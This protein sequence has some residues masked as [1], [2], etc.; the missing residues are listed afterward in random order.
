[1]TSLHYKDVI[2]SAMASQSP[3]LRLFNQLF[4]QAQIRFRHR[5]KKTS[6]L[7]VTGFCE[8]N[9]PVTG[10]F[11]AQRASNAE[12]VS[13]WWRYHDQGTAHL[14]LMTL[15][16]WGNCA[17][18]FTKSV[19]PVRGGC[20]FKCV[21][22]LPNLGFD[23]VSIQVNVTMEWTPDLLDGTSSLVQVMA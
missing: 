18:I 22:F 20:D 11:P 21:H 5:S 15:Y 8:G 3:A 19:T 23:I 6:K 16:A 13:I 12:N 14:G 17:I 7:R 9:S 10:E 2:M 4:I 1:M